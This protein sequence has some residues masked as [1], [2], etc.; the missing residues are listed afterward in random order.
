MFFFERKLNCVKSTKNKQNK[1]TQKKNQTGKPL[2]AIIRKY[3]DNI[4][5]TTNDETFNE[6]TKELTEVLCVCVCVCLFVNDVA[7]KGKT[8]QKKIIKVVK[9]MER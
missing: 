9:K 8:K 3:Y 2:K 4:E 1:N 7:K 6:I 5:D